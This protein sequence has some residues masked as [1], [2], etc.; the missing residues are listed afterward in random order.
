MIY[1]D[2]NATS[3]LRPAARAAWLEAQDDAWA[4]PASVHAGGQ[5]ARLVWD[6]A[7]ARCAAVLG[8][9][10]E[11]LVALSGG[12]EANATAIHA[13]LP[14]GGVAVATMLEHSSVLRNLEM[15]GEIRRFAVDAGGRVQP[16]ALV[17]ALAC[18]PRLVCLQLANNE[19][20]VVQD[21]PPLIALVR[22][23]APNALV[24]VDACQAA[25]KIPL[26][27]S[28][29]GA[30]FVAI[31]GHKCG[32]PKGV[33]LL[34]VRS[35]LRLKP[36]I[37][38]GRQ[39]QDRRSGTEDAVALAALAAALED[40]AAHLDAQALAHREWLAAAWSYI[41]AALP[42]TRWLAPA[43][44]RLSNT[45]AL[46]HPGVDNRHLH[47]RLDLAGFAVSTGAACMAAR[48]EPSHVALALGLEPGLAR[49]LIRVSLG[50]NTSATD[51]ARFAEA[52]VREVR[53]LGQ[54]GA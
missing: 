41:Q 17:E 30:D 35:G 25:G 12:S 31:A 33:G 22:A 52:Y 40:A 39:Q 50:W 23:Q 37:A 49:S 36:L 19:V 47:M 24:L 4:N 3:P 43:A 18:G 45:M 27:L 48:G 42:Q 1:L 7:R 16:D 5:Q 26:V 13:A 9:R 6:Q 14:A 51:V 28:G 38:G 32:A 2:H 46:V 34:Y 21:L 11:E 53:A 15:H 20:G 8:C 54:T 44:P 29:L 10:S